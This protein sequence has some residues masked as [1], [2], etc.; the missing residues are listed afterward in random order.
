MIN[1]QW[2]TS[3]FTSHFFEQRLESFI[4]TAWEAAFNGSLATPF[5]N[6]RFPDDNATA[7]S[8]L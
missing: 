2:L 4:D 6:R 5:Y 7:D 1:T 8:D 3:H